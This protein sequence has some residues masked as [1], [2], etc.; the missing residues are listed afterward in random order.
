M[1]L[2]YFSSQ[3]C[4]TLPPVSVAVEVTWEALDPDGTLDNLFITWTWGKN[5]K[6]ES[7]SWV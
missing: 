7:K 6:D 4:H 2:A 1:R 3:L 5:E